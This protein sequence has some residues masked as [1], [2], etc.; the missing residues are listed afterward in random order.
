MSTSFRIACGR[1]T[2][3]PL[4]AGALL[5]CT[6][7]GFAEDTSARGFALRN[8]HPFHQLFGLPAFQS[9]DLTASGQTALEF[10]IDFT[11]HAD[12]GDNSREDFR[13][14]GETHF[15]TLSLRR[16]LADW[17]ELG[18]DVPF[19]S[20][21][22][23]YMD[24]MIESWHDLWSLSN[25]KRD[26]P[27]NQLLYRYER[28][29]IERLFFDSSES[30]LG[31]VQLSAAVPIR[32]GAD[33]QAAITVRSSVKLPTGDS[34]KLL[35]SGAAD[36]ATGLYFADTRTLRDR[37]L[38]IGGFAGVLVLGEGDVLRDLQR[39]AVVFGGLSLAWQFS[40]R[41]ALVSHLYAQGPYF[42]SDLEELGGES[43]QLALGADYRTRGGAL[44]RF[45][46]VED[47]AA[48]A[49][50]DFAVHFSLQAGGR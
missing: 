28:D 22:D 12:E 7:I 16:R 21:T 6:S 46:I 20:H 42:D 26:G 11:N 50:P 19:V 8:Q 37:A 49:T 29:G 43:L 48:N 4:L 25:T 30:G 45:A 38:G 32:D 10:S 1:T 31:D 34:G 44:L 27:S 17:L 36:F 3:A 9:A 24:D 18:I 35:G 14:D 41:T 2:L 40:E 47:I 39:D 15:L 23:G 33:G 13:I 5:C